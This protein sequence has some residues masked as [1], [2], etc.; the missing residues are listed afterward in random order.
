MKKKT[1][2]PVRLPVA[3]PSK[4]HKDPTKYDRK[5]D[6]KKIPTESLSIKQYLDIQEDLNLSAMDPSLVGLYS[7]CQAL[8]KVGNQS[9]YPVPTVD[10]VRTDETNDELSNPIDFT[11]S[12]NSFKVYINPKISTVSLRGRGHDIIHAI[13]T[14]IAKKFGR[15]RPMKAGQ[16][17]EFGDPIN[18]TSS[19]SNL[20]RVSFKAFEPFA[21][22]LRFFGIDYK[23]LKTPKDIRDVIRQLKIRLNMSSDQVEI[24]LIHKMLRLLP[25]AFRDHWGPRLDITKG[26]RADKSFEKYIGNYEEKYGKIDHFART[27][28]DLPQNESEEDFGNLINEQIMKSI[29]GSLPI[30]TEE[31]MYSLKDLTVFNKSEDLVSH[32]NREWFSKFENFLVLLFETYNKLLSKYKSI[33]QKNYVFETKHTKYNR[34]KNDIAEGVQQQQEFEATKSLSIKQYFN[35]EETRHAKDRASERGVGISNAQVEELQTQLDQLS[36]AITKAG[37]KP[38]DFFETE[39]AYVIPYSN[40]MVIVALPDR[41]HTAYPTLRV[42]TILGPGQKPL[43]EYEMFLPIAKKVKEELQKIMAKRIVKR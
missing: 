7:F 20:R 2:I 24:N 13:T 14:N 32:L 41:G 10:I 19:R 12:A 30:N 31:V 39:K 36:A 17:I 42:M 37:R 33:S 16:E 26:S 35:I 23:S 1:K 4:K 11:Y 5:R 22:E 43:K 6:K 40:G 34:K 3:P 38:S 21:N 8:N 25:R 15:R 29:K 28:R 9:P 27:S 18:G